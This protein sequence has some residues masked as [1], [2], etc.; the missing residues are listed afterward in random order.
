M[1]REA[2][3]RRRQETTLATRKA[4]P[5]R[6]PKL[7]TDFD[8]LE[9]TSIS[10]SVSTSPRSEEEENDNLIKRKG[11]VE[12]AFFDTSYGGRRLPTY[13]L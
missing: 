11:T 4:T 12:P 10:C 2:R 1:K 6:N 8:S 7:P 3:R 13:V 5:Q 9:M